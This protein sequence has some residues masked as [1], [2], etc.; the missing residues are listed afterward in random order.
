ML[1]L[2][3]AK[4]YVSSLVDLIFCFAGTLCIGTGIF[5]LIIGKIDLATTGL[6]SGLLLLFAATIDR[7]ESLKGLG[8]E[9]K[10]RELKE[11][12]TEANETLIQLR[13]LAEVSG[14]TLNS[15]VAK[16][17]RSFAVKESHELA[18]EIKKNLT[19]L[20]SDQASIVHALRPWVQSMCGELAERLAVAFNTDYYAIEQKF[21]NQLQATPYT[22]GAEDPQREELI[23]LYATIERHKYGAFDAQKWPAEEALTNLR[24]HVST[25]PKADEQLIAQHLAVIDS[26]AE[27]VD[28]ILKFS[29]LKSPQRWTDIFIR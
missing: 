14:K 17:G 11:T 8:L 21:V 9:A 23:K 13:Q 29:D 4:T 16:S 6:G 18:Q 22:P 20:K 28:Y 24:K 10:T 12:I 27:E 3:R 2:H 19:E 1:K 26:W 25:A 15:L 7:F 5:Y